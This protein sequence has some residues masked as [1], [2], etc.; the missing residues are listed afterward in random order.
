MSKSG[1]PNNQKLSGPRP[2]RA[3][4]IIPTTEPDPP[5]APAGGEQRR[6]APPR[7][8]GKRVPGDK[9]Q[10]TVYLI[11]TVMEEAKNAAQ[12]L[13]STPGAP[14]GYSD[15]VNQAIEEKVARLQEEFHRGKPFPPRFGELPR[16]P[17]LS[18]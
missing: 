14:N 3:P 7:K 11:T 1:L 18:G 5:V 13:L 10:S 16:G 9:Q 15:L 12:A 2:A 4:E 8:G 17:A 6:G